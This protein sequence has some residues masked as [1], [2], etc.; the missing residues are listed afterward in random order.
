MITDP[1]SPQTALQVAED[2]LYRAL[3]ALQEIHDA[4]CKANAEKITME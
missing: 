4:A 2:D 1:P 3:Y